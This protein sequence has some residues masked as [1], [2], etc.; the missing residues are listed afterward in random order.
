[1]IDFL[2]MKVSLLTWK[3]EP[4]V[5]YRQLLVKE[6][7]LH[8]RGR[9]FVREGAPALFGKEGTFAHFSSGQLIVKLVC[10]KKALSSS[11]K[12]YVQ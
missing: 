7:G 1:M 8:Q 4:F 6:S 9:A 3:I 2:F 10:L 12:G 5:L 11:P